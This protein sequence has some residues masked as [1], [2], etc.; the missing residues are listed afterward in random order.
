MLAEALAAAGL[1]A[2]CFSIAVVLL[3]HSV[4]EEAVQEAVS[5]MW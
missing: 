4:S 3:F 5:M 2:F 1:L